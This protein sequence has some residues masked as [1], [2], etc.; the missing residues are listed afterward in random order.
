V[1]R[2][3]PAGRRETRSQTPGTPSGIPNPGRSR[4]PGRRPR[5][6]ATESG[7]W[8]GVNFAECFR[9]PG[10]FYQQTGDIRYLKA[11]ERNYDTML[12]SITGDV[13]WLDRCEEIAFNSLPASMP[14][15]LKGLHYLTCPN[16]VQ[17]DHVDK[18]PMVQNG[19]NMFAYDPYGFRCCQH[20][21]AFAW[22]YLA[23]HLWMATPDKE[24]A[25]AR[26]APCE[27][28]AKVAVAGDHAWTEATSPP[29]PLLQREGSSSLLAQARPPS[30]QEGVRGR[31]ET[32]LPDSRH[33]D[34][35][36]CARCTQRRDTSGHLAAGFG[37]SHSS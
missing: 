9:E 25:A 29:A 5:R 18:S 17:L 12:A 30:S 19:G 24:L 22:P 28:S 1:T 7:A 20:N 23:E 3:T 8:D 14:P 26:Y 6:F 36:G 15:D 16:Q 10:Q 27:V 13:K 21:V 35:S 2:R 37:L 32:P 31:F 4:S 34:Y 33:F 11:A